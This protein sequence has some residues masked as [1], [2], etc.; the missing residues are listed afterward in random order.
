MKSMMLTVLRKMEIQDVPDPVIVS[1]D[2]V[3]IKMTVVGI[4]GS[5]VHY[6]TQGRIGSQVVGY[7]FAVGHEGAGVVT[8][9]GKNVKNVK[10]GDAIAID[11]AMP[12]WEC[13]Q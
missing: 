2:D 3:K 12:C 5:D 10:P 6:Y 7:P 9:V 1:P 13:D 4:C 8:E 11:P